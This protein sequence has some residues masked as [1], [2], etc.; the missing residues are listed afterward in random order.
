M[1]IDVILLQV[2]D[3]TDI[4]EVM[5]LRAAAWQGATRVR[6]AFPVVACV[7]MDTPL[8]LCKDWRVAT[9]LSTSGERRLG[10]RADA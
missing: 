5:G 10:A 1:C 9:S 7:V 6:T 4:F 3:G 8:Y 2:K